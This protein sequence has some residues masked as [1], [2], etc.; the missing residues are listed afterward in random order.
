MKRKRL[1]LVALP[2]LCASVL[3]CLFYNGVLWFNNPSVRT[4]PVRGVDVSA[5]QGTID[6]HILSG[7]GISFAFIKATEGC[8][9]RDKRFEEN[10][11]NANKTALKIGAYHFFSFDSL[12]SAQAD[13]FISAVPRLKKALPP[14]VDIELSGSAGNPPDK[15]RTRADLN[16]LLTALK[17]YYGR[18]PI[19]YVTEQTY[20]LYIQG[21]YGDYPIWIRNILT[22]PTLPD[23][24]VWTFWQYSNRRELK[25]YQ[26]SERFI[27]MD[28][29]S[30]T[31]AQFE[32]LYG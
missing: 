7:Q 1:L 16:E 15:A 13:N 22:S 12:G 5:Y 23:R 18:K 21:G 8:G 9:F 27:D 11:A 30:G 19:L 26:G 14:V 32:H 17:R 28:V 10:W 31:E 3:G 24:R 2:V 20:G 25:G 6:W 29:F 4:Y